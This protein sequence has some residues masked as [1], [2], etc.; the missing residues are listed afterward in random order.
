M[1]TTGLNFPATV[2][3]LHDK[4]TECARPQGIP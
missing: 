2:A 3:L 4:M 1:L